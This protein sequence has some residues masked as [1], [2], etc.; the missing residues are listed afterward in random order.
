MLDAIQIQTM[1]RSGN[2]AFATIPMFN[3]R[4]SC[5]SVQSFEWHLEQFR[6][7]R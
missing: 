3:F 2:G 1:M 6:I 4:A 7:Q 5:L